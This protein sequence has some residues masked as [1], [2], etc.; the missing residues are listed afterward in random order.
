ML[1]KNSEAFSFIVPF[2]LLPLEASRVSQGIRAGTVAGHCNRDTLSTCQG[3]A[4]PAATPCPSLGCAEADARWIQND[5]GVGV[6]GISGLCGSLQ[7]PLRPP[8]SRSQNLNKEGWGK[9][10]GACTKPISTLH[11]WFLD[12]SGADS[13]NTSI[14]RQEGWRR[15]AH[16]PDR[17]S[18]FRA[19][20]S[21]SRALGNTNE[22]PTVQ[23]CQ[24]PTF[25]CL[26]RGAQLLKTSLD[27]SNNL[28]LPQMC[29]WGTELQHRSSSP[30]PSPRSPLVSGRQFPDPNFLE[31]T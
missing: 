18:G 30:H 24:S 9:W 19:V 15:N 26:M 20:L 29:L 10:K 16:L 22:S 3:S 23:L 8:G 21:L 28:K 5:L 1:K 14:S 31:I 17:I 12:F 2:P 25:I 13:Q 11:F 27:S 6:E 4:G 7:M